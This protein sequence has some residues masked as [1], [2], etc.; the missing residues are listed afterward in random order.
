MTEQVE[1]LLK[2]QD[3]PAGQSSETAKTPRA[4]FDQTPNQIGAASAN[5]TV[6]NPSI[7][8]T[9]NRDLSDRWRFNSGDSP[10]AP[11]VEDFNFSEHLPA[12]GMDQVD[13][14]FPWEMI[15]LGLEEPLPPQETID[16]L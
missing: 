15:G 11:N 12:M 13:S 7:A 16:E 1:T 8:I 2:T 9:G 4:A 10:S 6:T 14:S 5:F 3:P